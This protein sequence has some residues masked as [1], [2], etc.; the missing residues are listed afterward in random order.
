MPSIWADYS[1]VY[2]SII[3]SV[4]VLMEKKQILI[5]TELVLDCSAVMVEPFDGKTKFDVAKDVIQN[6]LSSEA[7]ENDNLAF[8]KYGGPCEGENNWLI[9]KFSTNNEQQILKALKN[10]TII[11]EATLVD[12]VIEA[13][14]DFNDIKQFR[15]VNKRIIVITGSN[16]SCMRNSINSMQR[17][18]EARRN[19]SDRIELSFRFIGLGISHVLK[20]RLI[21]IAKATGGRFS[22]FF[23]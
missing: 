16:E 19:E 17:R 15:G 3:K 13:T 1:E 18:L 21:E 10:T 22:N 12:A 9:V 7:A 11:G 4:A 23:Y 2:Q 20:E 5:N 6:I 8:R 14:G